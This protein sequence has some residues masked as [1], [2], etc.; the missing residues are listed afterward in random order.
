MAFLIAPF[1]FVKG[2]SNLQVYAPECE[3][4]RR[5]NSSQIMLSAPCTMCQAFV[6]HLLLARQINLKILEKK[7]EGRRDFLDSLHPSS[8]LYPDW[9]DSAFVL[10]G[11]ASPEHFKDAFPWIDFDLSAV[12]LWGEQTHPVLW[13][14]QVDE[15]IE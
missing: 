2:F 11:S 3:S 1:F 15:S 8:G 5:N 4:L 13:S 10:G 7:K 14:W 12:K 9:N 6:W